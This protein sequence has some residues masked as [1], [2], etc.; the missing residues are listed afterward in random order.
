VSA[1][2]GLFDDVDPP[3][4]APG[5]ARDVRPAPVPAALAAV[6]D[7][8]PSG[9]HLGTSSWSFPGWAGIVYARE[10]D[11]TTLARTGLAAYAAQPWLR[12][13]SIDRTYYGPIGAA[14]LAG[15][16]AVVPPWF[17]FMVKAP[18][19]LTA[20]TLR[21]D[22]GL[23]RDNPNWLDARAATRLFVAPCVDG[24]G[25]HGGP[26]VFQ[27]PPQ[28]PRVVRDP[29]AFAGRVDALL[30]GLPR[31]P[32]YAFELRDAALWT[33]TLGD[34]LAHHGAVWCLSV[35]PRAAS[36]ERQSELLA[37]MPPGPVVARWNLNPRHRYE[38]AKARYAPFDRLVEQDP[39]SRHALAAWAAD[40]LEAD[41]PVHIVVN[42]KA[43]GSAP[44]SL[45]EL[46]GAI[47][48]RR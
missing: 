24:L 26:L 7:R 28:G 16:A 8:W 40:A 25:S 36:L 21:D 31:G 29:R 47:A 9:L 18:A 4:A 43:E 41:R 27:C 37:R 5:R 3:P 20:P 30:G 1:Q 10:H 12:T 48:A 6:V 46:F 33:D 34:V 23:P 22:A 15:Y 14:E 2:S 35:H 44:L 17:R 11:A 13:V 38:E 42:N 32:L 39:V 45:A 19:E